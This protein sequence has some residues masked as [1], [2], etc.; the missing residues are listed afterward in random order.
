M[1]GGGLTGREGYRPVVASSLNMRTEQRVRSLMREPRV[2]KPAGGTGQAPRREIDAV[3][4]LSRNWSATV[5]A[6]AIN[7]GLDGCIGAPHLGDSR[8]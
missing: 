6:P 8:D 3:S 4:A 2:R 1:G 7:W 5:E